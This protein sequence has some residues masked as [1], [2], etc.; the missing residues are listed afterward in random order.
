MRTRVELDGLSCESV[1]DL[2]VAGRRVC[3]RPRSGLCVPEGGT[4]DFAK[5]SSDGSMAVIE[6][7]VPLPGAFELF[8]SGSPRGRNFLVRRGG[9]GGVD[10]GWEA[11]EA[12]RMP[13]D[14][15][16]GGSPPTFAEGASGL[17]PGVAPA[18]GS[19]FFSFRLSTSLDGRPMTLDGTL[20]GGEELRPFP[21]WSDSVSISIFRDGGATETVFRLVGV[22]GIPTGRAAFDGTR[23]LF[24]VLDG[25][26]SPVGSLVVG[27]GFPAAGFDA[28]AGAIV[29]SG[30]EFG[31]GRWSEVELR[32][33]GGDAADEAVA[34]LSEFLDDLGIPSRS[35]SF[36]GAGMG[37][38][39]DIER[40][41]PGELG[42]AGSFSWLESRFDVE[43]LVS[44]AAASASLPRNVAMIERPWLS[45]SDSLLTERGFVGNGDDDPDR[46]IG[47]LTPGRFH[48]LG[49][50]LPDGLD[51]GRSTAARA[52]SALLP[53]SECRGCPHSAGCSALFPVPWPAGLTLPLGSPCRLASAFSTRR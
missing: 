27:E 6:L 15:T 28:F 45:G 17:S 32:R 50:S 3:L 47:R 46:P 31:S 21:L 12:S 51:E 42:A 41:V 16:S 13:D 5:F 25:G 53:S 34:F 1:S 35:R 49:F 33:T 19:G 29:R 26:R 36:V 18:S 40:L 9:S 8:R 2:E 37:G 11:G 10:D 44:A 43:R 22:P 20:S 30:V 24:G 7:F 38:V 39:G 52:R 48:G 4:A 23:G 14:G